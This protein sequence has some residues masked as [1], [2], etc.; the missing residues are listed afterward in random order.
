MIVSA[1]ILSAW[2]ACAP[3]AQGSA[4]ELPKEAVARK[5]LDNGLTIFAK[6]SP[7]Q[8]LVAIDVTILAGKSLEGEYLGSG[9]SHLVEH[10]VFK[11]TKTRGVGAIEREVKSYGGIINGSTSADLTS[12]YMLLPSDRLSEGLDILRDMLANATFDAAELSRE[13]EVILKEINLSDDDPQSRLIKRLHETAYLRHPYKYPAIGYPERFKTLSREDVIKYY[14]TMYTP[15]RTVVSIAG[16]ID[17]EDAILKAEAA[18]KDY[19]QPNY[20]PV[21]ILSIEPV[22]LGVRRI[23]EP[24]RVNLGYLAMGFHS[25]SVLDEDLFAMDVLAMILGRGDNSRLSASLFKQKKLVH[26]IA[27]WNNTPKDPGLFVI[28]AILDGENAE[29]AERAVLEEVEAISKDGISDYELDT[30]RRMVLA[31]Y[32]RSLETVDAQ[33]DSI[34]TNYILTGSPD[35]SV[36]YVEGIQKVSKEDVRSAANKYLKDSNLTVAKL[37]PR[38][39][40]E[41]PANKKAAVTEAAVIKD[42]LKNGLRVIVRKESKTPTVSI[43]LVMLGGLMVENEANNGISNLTAQMLLKGTSSRSEDRIKGYIESLGGFLY[44]FSGIS[45]FGVRLDVLKTDLE[46]A[47]DVLQD[48]VA[49]S[50]FP[51]DEIDKEKRL[52][53]A[54]ISEEDNDIFATGFNTLRHEVFGKNPYGFRY[55]GEEKAVLSLD[56]DDLISFYGTYVVPNNIVLSISGDIDQDETLKMINKRFSGLARKDLDIP[57]PEGQRMTKSRE[58]PV[59]MDKEQSL[60]MLSFETVSALSDDRYTL[61]VLGSVLSGSSGRL[62]QSLRSRLG[63]AYSL[64]CAQKL[65]IGRGY[66]AFYTA[67]TKENIVRTRKA[68]QEEIAKIRQSGIT[69]EE[70]SLAKNELRVTRQVARQTNDFYSLTAGIDEAYGLGYD[71]MDRY[72]SRIGK[73]TKDDV[74]AVAQRYFNPEACAEVTVSSP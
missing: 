73:V 40:K 32:V 29:R 60:V 4:I 68:M 17:P 6:Y 37:I 38:D 15:N 48:I 53:L 9:I 30:A 24:S 13:K 55:I 31:D 27:A 19:R 65:G 12:Y 50:D 41:K 5:T 66:F 44:A 54:A 1:I 16:G 28:S 22:Q 7:P 8:G 51:K 25:T 14:N 43:A 56:R 72:D 58:R 49:N 34:G 36:R 74:M 57:V 70:L 26:S 61:E 63:L 52:I 64:G 46:P 62:F 69:D 20:A 59:L 23:E 39:D 71:I 45:S 67:T 10:M 3:G 2:A 33:A 47:L 42:T 18:F 11:G 21:G 35:F